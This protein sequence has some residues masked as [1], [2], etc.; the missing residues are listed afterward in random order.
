MEKI[1]ATVACVTSNICSPVWSR[2]PT[3][4]SPTHQISALPT[5]LHRVSRFSILDYRP[6]APSSTPGYP[7]S[8]LLLLLASVPS[9]ASWV[10]RSQEE[11]HRDVNNSSRDTPYIIIHLIHNPPRSPSRMIRFPTFR[12]TPTC[13]NASTAQESLREILRRSSECSSSPSPSTSS[14]SA[15]STSTTTS[16]YHQEKKKRTSSSSTSSTSSSSPRTPSPKK[17]NSASKTLHDTV[18][19]KKTS[20]SDGDW[21]FS[22]FSGR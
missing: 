17:V 5:P 19:P 13:Q 11:I 10:F 16:P 7:T 8:T 22:F 15:S 2:S 1:A 6:K 18:K 3:P 4:S 14:S 12:S 20:T 21:N 9:W